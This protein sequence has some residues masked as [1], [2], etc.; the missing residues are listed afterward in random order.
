MEPKIN[1]LS[2]TVVVAAS[3]VQ[4]SLPNDVSGVAVSFSVENYIGL[5]LYLVAMSCIHL[6]DCSKSLAQIE[7]MVQ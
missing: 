6:F 1:R 5:L 4:K 2:K 7:A 3:L